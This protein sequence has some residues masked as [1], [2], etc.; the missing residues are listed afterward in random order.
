MFLIMLFVKN[1]NTVKFVFS[2]FEN[3]MYLTEIAYFLA[4][5]N[6]NYI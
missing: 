3:K 6:I 5:K 4:I 1:R 2:L